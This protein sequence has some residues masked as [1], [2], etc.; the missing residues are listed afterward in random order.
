MKHCICILLSLLL[1]S[2]PMAQPIQPCLNFPVVIDT[3][4]GVT[5]QT[6]K[7]Y[8][9]QVGIKKTKS[10]ADDCNLEN[11]CTYNTDCYLFTIAESGAPNCS[12]NTY[13]SATTGKLHLERYNIHKPVLTIEWRNKKMYIVFNRMTQ[14]ERELFKRDSIIKIINDHNQKAGI[15]SYYMY[16]S[17]IGFEEGIYFLKENFRESGS[18]ISKTK[19]SELYET[20][21]TNHG[22]AFI[23]SPYEIQSG[24]RY[25]KT[26]P[27][28]FSEEQ[29]IELILKN[30][31]IENSIRDALDF[32]KWKLV[33][34]FIKQTRAQAFSGVIKRLESDSRNSRD[35][36]LAISKQ[37]SER[38]L[39]EKYS[40]YQ[41]N[42]FF[43]ILDNDYSLRIAFCDYLR[44]KNEVKK[45]HDLYKRYN[46]KMNIQK[47]KE[48]YLKEG[49]H[50]E[51][52]IDF[53]IRSQYKVNR[54]KLQLFINGLN[55][56]TK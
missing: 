12:H 51:E 11:V 43:S 36:L 28:S 18:W 32:A 46:Y 6:T 17:Q 5:V 13:Y 30:Q 21:R 27:G 38:E 52:F 53:M 49:N 4:K 25:H 48:Y 9:S 31:T 19:I 2:L 54:E 41:Q 3:I 22:E 50:Y 10:D 24:T 26:F 14:F 39:F 56:K 40:E 15:S 16:I 42:D 45:N 37:I 8:I 44:R 55:Q 1:Y 35:S 23:Y 29:A 34:G 33:N 47:L 20:E 7:V